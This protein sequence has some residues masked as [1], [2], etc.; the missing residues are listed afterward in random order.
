MKEYVKGLKTSILEGI[1][2]G[3]KDY[4]HVRTKAHRTM[5]IS[6]AYAYVRSNHI[7]HQVAMHIKEYMEFQKSNAGPS[8]KYLKFSGSGLSNNQPL[9]FILKN[10]KYFNAEAVTLGKN[11][12]N[13]KGEKEKEYLRELI[14]KN[15]NIDF[16]KLQIEY[17]NP[18]QMDWDDYL[19]NPNQNAT[20][21][22][23]EGI[24]NIITYNIDANT[25]MINSVKIWT[26]NPMNNKAIM[27]EDLSEEVMRIIAHEEDY[28][29]ENEEFKEF[30]TINDTEVQ[31][32]DP[33]KEFGFVFETEE[34]EKTN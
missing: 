32:V 30:Q 10:E 28:L 12:F 18:H 29:I 14:S 34:I 17:Q 13:K 11:A 19:S 4:I 2:H 3:Y 21:Q 25:K 15:Q 33:E 8:W 22:K 23:N 27:M 1:V 31:I 16:D 6:E 20:K 5:E 9:S 7:E 26:P 24:F